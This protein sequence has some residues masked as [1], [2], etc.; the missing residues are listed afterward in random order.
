MHIFIMSA[1]RYCDQACLFIRLFVCYAHDFSKTTS[2][3]FMQLGTDVWHLCYIA[4]LTIFQSSR[5]NSKVKTTTLFHLKYLGC[6]L[7][8]ICTKF[9]NMTEIFW[10]DMMKYITCDKIPDGGFF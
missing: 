1:G 8:F 9:G 6:D 4:L 3:I 10:H 2:L 5:S 7:R